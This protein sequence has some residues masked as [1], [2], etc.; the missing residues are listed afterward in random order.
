[1]YYTIL[2]LFQTTESQTLQSTDAIFFSVQCQLWLW[3]I[4]GVCL[5]KLIK[6]LLVFKR[7]IFLCFFSFFFLSSIQHRPVATY[8]NTDWFCTL[9]KTN[10]NKLLTHGWPKEY[11]VFSYLYSLY[12]LFMFSH[13]QVLLL[14]FFVFVLR[15][16]MHLYITSWGNWYLI[17]IY[18]AMHKQREGGKNHSSSQSPSVGIFLFVIQNTSLNLATCVLYSFN[19]S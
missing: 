11:K 8:E 4:N 16:F 14:M 6:K 7:N 2:L 9:T 19:I 3:I 12:D 18:T 15:L 13:M 17:K 10:K 1:M 5:K